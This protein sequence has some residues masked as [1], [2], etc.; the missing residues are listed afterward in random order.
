MV[1]KEGQRRLQGLISEI[2][3]RRRAFCGWQVP[4]PSQID[5]N[6]FSRE[7]LVLSWTFRVKCILTK[8]NYEMVSLNL[9]VEII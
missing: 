9:K 7:W 2:A 1:E 4:Q 8:V 6:S 5:T 3:L